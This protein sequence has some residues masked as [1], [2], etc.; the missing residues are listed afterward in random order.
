MIDSEIAITFHLTLKIFVWAYKMTITALEPW[1]LLELL[2]DSSTP[3]ESIHQV[4][5]S[6]N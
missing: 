3:V 5:A 6:S 1:V 2:S 4:A